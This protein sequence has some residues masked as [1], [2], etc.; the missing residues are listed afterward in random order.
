MSIQRRSIVQI[1]N[2]MCG[3]RRYT[4]HKSAIQLVR[5]GRAV[6]EADGS[7]IRLTDPVQ[8]P[9]RGASGGAGEGVFQWHRGRSGGLAQVLGSMAMPPTG[10][11]AS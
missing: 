7:A 5:R 6:W 9:Q 2:P 3:A 10:F 1:I 8:A 11:T 4:A